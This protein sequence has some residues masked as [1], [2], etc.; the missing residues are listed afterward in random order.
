[1]ETRLDIFPFNLKESF[2]EAMTNNDTPMYAKS[3]GSHMH[4]YEHLTNAL[5]LADNL[6]Q[7]FKFS[8]RKRRAIVRGALCHD[9]GKCHDIFQRNIN[10]AINKK[11]GEHP[12]YIQSEYGFPIRHELVSLLFLSTFPKSDWNTIIDMV[13]AHHKSIKSQDL[14]DSKGYGI[15]DLIDP[16]SNARSYGFNAVFDAISENW[17]VLYQ[18]ASTVFRQCGFEMKPISIEDAR[19]SF[20]YVYD[21]CHS[22]VKKPPRLK[23]GEFRKKNERKG[24]KKKGPSRYRG[25]LM[26][27]DHF[28]SALTDKTIEFH[29]R[30]FKAPN[31]SYYHTLRN[32]SMYPLSKVNI[33]SKK[34]HSLCVAPTGSG[35]TYFFFQRCGVMMKN[36]TYEGARV[37]YILPFQAA[38]N[39]MHKRIKEDLRA[40]NKK[41]V[42]SGK[43]GYADVDIRVVHGTS[44]LV[45]YTRE[46]ASDDDR[47]ARIEAKLQHLVGAQIKLM[48][49]H[50]LASII[51]GTHGYE[52][53]LLDVENCHCV[54]DELHSYG[55]KNRA[56]VLEII[57]QLVKHGCHIHIG[58][59]TIPKAFRNKILKILGGKENVHEVRLSMKELDTF[60]KHIIFKHQY[61][62]QKMIELIE[63]AVSE[64]K[65]TLVVLNTVSASQR[66]LEMVSSH[67]GTNIPI[68][69]IHSRFK[70]LHRANLEKHLDHLNKKYNGP[71]IVISTQVVEVSL[72]ISFDEMITEPCPIDSL[73]QRGGRINRWVS[74]LFLLA[75][76]EDRVRKIHIFEPVDDYFSCLPYDYKTLLATHNQFS[77]GEII[78]TRSLQ[79]K[80]DRVYPTINLPNLESVS[81]VSNPLPKLTSRRSRELFDLFDMD[82]VYVICESD[83]KEYQML[84]GQVGAFQRR[85]E[86][87]ISAPWYYMYRT[88]HGIMYPRYKRSEFGHCPFIVP[89]SMYNETYGLMPK[90]EIQE[91]VAMW[92]SSKNN[93]KAG[94]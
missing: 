43:E 58:S 41:L 52:A 35:K 88:E 83:D 82:S 7:E 6:A 69:L 70:K 53:M 56:M 9:I 84:E 33:S 80:I 87:E 72:D 94:V 92:E 39:S 8:R 68:M 78:R 81:I 67:F 38:L 76:V 3:G 31:L 29:D 19:K 90:V 40:H 34:I 74:E 79:A 11:D 63:N 20:L 64:G 26:A 50:Q 59:A 77:D 27:L 61:S 66:V 24:L 17:D 75:A 49:P 48:T 13:V 36:G 51:L 42:E 37:F 44:N 1:M 5:S 23:R 28:A 21:R 32:N 47:E 85:L 62:D 89:D 15:I 54:F 12:Q 16:V 57:R 93:M 18:N 14:D 2:E 55:D 4:L 86:M 25:F 91:M 30:M 45:P 71:C 10:N 60:D 73:I 46:T 65:K 22:F